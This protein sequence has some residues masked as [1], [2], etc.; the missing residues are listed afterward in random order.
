MRRREGR[1]PFSGRR[2]FG[3]FAV[4]WLT[5]LPA[6]AAAHGVGGRID[7]PVPL[8][9]FLAG[10]IAVLVV[11]FLALLWLWP[12]PR[13]QEPLPLRQLRLPGWRFVATGFAVIGVIGVAIV[14]LAGM[15]GPDNS[16]RNPAPVLV[17][18]ILWLVV[19]FAGAVVG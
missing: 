2:V 17:W 10:A 8:G 16:V 5:V 19:P 4:I 9:Y 13:L 7:L 12:H 18:V 6:P 11:T 15:F 14:V 3:A 1:N